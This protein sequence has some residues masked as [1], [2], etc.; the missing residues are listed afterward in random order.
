M[1]F[2]LHGG[3]GCEKNTQTSIVDFGLSMFDCVAVVRG[4]PAV[5]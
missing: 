2:E 1:G 3:R 4:R 5:V